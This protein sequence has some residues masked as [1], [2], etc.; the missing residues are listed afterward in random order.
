MERPDDLHSIKSALLEISSQLGKTDPYFV[1]SNSEK[2]ATLTILPAFKELVISRLISEKIISSKFTSSDKKIIAD[3]LTHSVQFY[4]SDFV[5]CVL[6][7]N[8]TLHDYTIPPLHN[9][10]LNEN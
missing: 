4:L 9:N 2:G 10:K 6:G 8:K 3:A 7:G 1:I 5:M